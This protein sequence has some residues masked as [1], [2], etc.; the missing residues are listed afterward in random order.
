[1][2]ATATYLVQGEILQITYEAVTDAPTVVNLANHGYWN[3]DGSPTVDGHYLALA[4]DQVLPVDDSGIP[5]GS[6]Q[7]VEGSPF[8]LRTRN[9]LGPAMVA[10]PPGFDHCFA[11]KG[12]MGVLRSAAV[13]DAPA[14]GR[15]M[16]VRTDQPGIQ[17]YTGNHLGNPFRVHGSVSLETQRFPDTPNRPHLGSALLVPGERYA[18]LTELRFGVGEPPPVSAS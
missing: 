7:P 6:L 9:R 15:W 18:S 5:S 8:D 1:M 13:L 16:S 12:Q 3:L 14:S 4:A 11:V 10:H 17:L 2:T